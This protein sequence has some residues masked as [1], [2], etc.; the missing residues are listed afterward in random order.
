VLGVVLTLA[1]SSGGGGSNGLS[2]FANYYADS[3][4]WCTHSSNCNIVSLAN[5]QQNW[6]SAQTVQRAVDYIGWTPAQ[7]SRC[8]RS[9]R[10]LDQCYFATTC[11]A[12]A[13]SP[14]TGCETQNTAFNTDCK[15]L[16]DALALPQI[17][18]PPTPD[19]G[20]PSTGTPI[21]GGAN[22]GAALCAKVAECQGMPLSA[23]DRADCESTVNQTFV[24]VPD[25]SGTVS[26]LQQTDCSSLMSNTQQV[27]LGCVSIDPTTTHCQANTLHVCNT[28][29]ICR[30][31]A[32]AD[33][34]A[35]ISLTSQGCAF[36]ANA[37]YDKCNCS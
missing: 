34:C 28:Q 25:P 35:T 31:V 21:A 23:T 30:D 27:T 5:C 18:N 16:L 3:T 17:S 9:S 1:C 26:C 2:E 32:C 6:P 19:A 8:E 13:A 12:A 22:V 4:Q 10:A 11:T 15:A 14:P 7:V 36:D 37:G 29:G 33:A 24:V 20:T